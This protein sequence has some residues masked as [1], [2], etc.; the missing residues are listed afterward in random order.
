VPDITWIKLST[1]IFDDEKIKLI[2]SLPDADSVLIIWIKLLVLA[3]RANASGHIFL[4]DGSPYTDEMLAAILNRPLNTIRLALAT[5]KKYGL[6]DV[7]TRG[8]FITNW[9]KH[10]N[11]EGMARV[12]E[13]TRLRV[14]KHREHKKSLTFGIEPATLSNVTVTQQNRTDIE[15]NQNRADKR[16]KKNKIKFSEAV[17]L[18]QEEFDKLVEQFGDEGAQDRITNLS[19]YKLSKGKEY[20]SDYATIL[21]WERRPYRNNGHKNNGHS[22]RDPGK[23][24]SPLDQFREKLRNGEDLPE[25]KMSSGNARILREDCIRNGWNMPEWLKC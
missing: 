21:T 4:M 22:N 24:T 3:G 13:Q 11:I 2:E 17:F 7:T 25:I 20:K 14:A 10:Q 1:G 6:I 23:Y 9:A 12:L 18:S 8:L 16:Q 15:K 5:F 19:L